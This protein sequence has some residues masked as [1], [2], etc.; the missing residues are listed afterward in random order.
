MKE[1]G[2][3]MNEQQIRAQDYRLRAEELR[4]LA[5]MDG[6]VQTTATLM[7]IANDYERMAEIMDDID[8]TN[9]SLGKV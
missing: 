3:E 1:G 6:R 5:E 9:R 8:R 4:A 7:D 2:C